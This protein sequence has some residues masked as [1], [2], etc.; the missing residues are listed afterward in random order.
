MADKLVVIPVS[1]KEANEYVFSFHRHSKPTQGHKFS[2]GAANSYGLWG[3]AII[4]RPIARRM[5]NGLTLE[6][7][8]TCVRPEAPRNVNSFLYGAAWRAV[9]CLG[10]EKLITYTLVTESG[11]SLR[12]AGWKIIGETQPAGK[13]AWCGPNRHRDWQPIYGQKKFRWEIALP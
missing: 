2:I 12:G 9:R 13:G 10:Y 7:L 3:V 8:R 5:D 6:V 1:L 11:E 4:G